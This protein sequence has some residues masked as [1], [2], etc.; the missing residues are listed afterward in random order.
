MPRSQG[1]SRKGKPSR[2]D[3][4]TGL[5]RALTKGRVAVRRD[6]RKIGTPGLVVPTAANN[7]HVN[8]VTVKDDATTTTQQQQQHPRS[9]LEVPDLQDFLEQADLAQSEFVSI[10]EGLVVLDSSATTTAA[11]SRTMMHHQHHHLDT[12]K[13]ELSVPR[14]PAWNEFTT[15]AELEQLEK[16]AFYEWRRGIAVHEAALYNQQQQ[17]QTIYSHGEN[18][19]HVAATTTST[20]SS[21]MVATTTTTTTPFERNLD[22]WR[23]LWRVLERSACLCQVVDARQPLFYLSADLRRYA[24][25]ESTPSKPVMVIVNKSDYL[26]P[27]QRVV[28][29]RH[30]QDEVHWASVVFFSAT[31][32]QAKLDAL[33]KQ[34]QQ[35]QLENNAAVVDETT[36]SDTAL[37]LLD[38]QDSDS[39]DEEGDEEDD[40]ETDILDNDESHESDQQHHHPKEETPRLDTAHELDDPS[41]LHDTDNG[42]LSEGKLPLDPSD[43][44][45]LD[46]DTD[47]NDQDQYN[48]EAP[49]LTRRELIDAMLAFAQEHNCPRDPRYDNRIQFGMVGFPNVGK[50]SVI[51][52][53]VG[54]SRHAHG[55]ARVAVAAQPGKTKH[56]QTLLL[57]PPNGDDA[58]DDALMLCDCPGLVFPSLVSQTADLIAAGVYP[59][60]QMRDYW[61]VMHLICQRIPRDILNAQYGIQLP[62]PKAHELREQQQQQQALSPAEYEFATTYTNA[63]VLLDTFCIARSLLA[64][65]SG[66]PDHARAARRMVKDYACGALLYCHAPPLLAP[67]HRTG[68]LPNDVNEEQYWQ[69]WRQ[70]TR[71]TALAQ[72]KRLREKASALQEL[73]KA[74]ANAVNTA[75]DLHGIDQD[76]MAM[77]GASAAP[78]AA[79]AAGEKSHKKSNKK[80]SATPKSKWGKKDR[81]NRNKD[82]YGCHTNTADGALYEEAAAAAAATMTGSGGVIVNAGKYS[83]TGYTRPMTFPT[84]TVRP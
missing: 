77:I 64:S 50:S 73:P 1:T 52:V 70:E 75:E 9:V 39:D 33:F 22:V 69:T 3:Q 61:P 16:N 7:E 84:T 78:N 40:S 76:L 54:S 45:R 48:K 67:K 82:P 62:V 35:Q 18:N 55:L 2:H 47:N 38:E 13:V 43:Q 66:V 20:N 51:N 6:P 44:P 25:E 37:P 21:S 53:L 58:D 56:F 10:R 72:T 63:K 24:Q 11:N 71:R 32:E 57:P 42:V 60:A 59:I 23:Q 5:G 34:Q 30:L 41:N 79:P 27:Y 29:K 49:L 8:G 17:Q 46:S 31:L 19:S 83:Q 14:R 26:T 28:W 81:K 4:A 74:A 12:T 36:H 80:T 68:L 15:K 65:F